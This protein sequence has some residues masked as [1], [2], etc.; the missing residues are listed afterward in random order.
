[1]ADVASFSILFLKVCLLSC[2]SGPGRSKEWTQSLPF[3]GQIELEGV[4]R[5]WQEA[6]PGPGPDP[7]TGTAAGYKVWVQTTQ[8]LEARKH[9]QR[10]HLPV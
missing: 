9:R 6:A 2:L 7:D 5:A 1:M 3:L 8:F 10:I 4:L